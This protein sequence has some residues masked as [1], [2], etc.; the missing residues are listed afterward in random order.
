MAEFR[1]PN[2]GGSGGSQDNRS[3]LIMMIVMIAVIFGLQYWRTQHNPP[4][5]SPEHPAAAAPA[6]T[7]PPAAAAAAPAATSTAATPATPTVAAPTESSTVVENELYRITFTNRGGQV[8]S[9]ILKNFNDTAGHPLDLVQD[10]AAKLYGYPLSLYTYDAGLTS[11][12]ANALY[13]PSATGTLQS[14]ATLSFSYAAGNLTVHKTFTFG[15]DYLVHADTVVL[16]DGVPI[17]AL[18]SWPAGLGDMESATGY[19]GAVVDT[20]VNGKDE[21]EAFKKVSGGATLPGPFDFAGISDQYFAAIFLPDSPADASF[22]TFHHDVDVKEIVTPAALVSLRQ[23][24]RSLLHRHHPGLLHPHQGHPQGPCPRRR[25]R[26]PLRPHP[27]PS[28]R[29]PQVPARPQEHQHRRRQPR[30]RA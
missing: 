23:H 30:P 11:A 29:R 9:W 24:H 6:T 15:A 10:G 19:A 22:A 2:Q 7:A 12:L 13:V 26:R 3:F 28:L 16:R 27:H 5:T 8:S 1:N 25:R 18:L 21:H 17:R 4:A 20:S 14:P